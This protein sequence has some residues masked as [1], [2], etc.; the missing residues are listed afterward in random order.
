MVEI[1]SSRIFERI[2]KLNPE[3]R[4]SL[5]SLMNE[6]FRHIDHFGRAGFRD[7]QVALPSL[8]SNP[9]PPRGEIR[10]RCYDICKWLEMY[11]HKDREDEILDKDILG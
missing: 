3:H 4:K 9:L 8:S 2:K 5:N 11:I 6:I 7:I 10:T 1:D